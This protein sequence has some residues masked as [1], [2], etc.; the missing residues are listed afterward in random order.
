MNLANTNKI[1]IHTNA[2]SVIYCKDGDHPLNYLY[3]DYIQLGEPRKGYALWKKVKTPKIG[4][5]VTHNNVGTEVTL[6]RALCWLLTGELAPLNR[7]NKK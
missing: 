5:R 4:R 1:Q 2:E 3:T 6:E 7:Q